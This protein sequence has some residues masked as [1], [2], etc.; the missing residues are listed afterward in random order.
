MYV[1]DLL[2]IDK[3]PKI[4]FPIREESIESPKMYLGADTKKA[5]T[6]YSDQFWCICAN[7]CIK[8]ALFIVQERLHKDGVQIKGKGRQPYS[9]L[10][11]CTNQSLM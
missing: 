8:E 9:T 3:D 10:S 5:K 2:C 11:Y 1:D 4:Y 6:P 7:H